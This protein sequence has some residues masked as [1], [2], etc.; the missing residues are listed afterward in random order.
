MSNSSCSISISQLPCKCI[1][2][3][4]SS[5]MCT[6]TAKINGMHWTS[7]ALLKTN[8]ALSESGVFQEPR[9]CF[10][11][12]CRGSAPHPQEPPPSQTGR[13]WSCEPALGWQSA[14]W[15]ADSL[16][17]G[18]LSPAWLSQWRCSVWST[19]VSLTT[20]GSASLAPA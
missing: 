18:W 7:F 11:C 4:V 19:P 8:S 12:A 13:S 20:L 9:V 3:H 1:Q 16:P 2:K 17:H 14:L 6:C 5:D 10:Q 15:A